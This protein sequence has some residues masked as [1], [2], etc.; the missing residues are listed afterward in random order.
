MIS[1]IDP[2]V[3]NVFLWGI[4]LSKKGYICYNPSTRELRVSWDVVFDEMASW[5]NDEKMSIGADV[6]EIVDASIGKQ[7]SQPLS[8][9]RE[10]S[11]SVSVDKP[12]SGRLRT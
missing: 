9:P 10:S 6:K 3:E 2:K 7:E 5:Y 12:W 4:H 8:G 11:S 1:K